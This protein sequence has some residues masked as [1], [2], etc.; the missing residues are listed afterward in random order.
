MECFIANP[1]LG[2]RFYPTLVKPRRES[3]LRTTEG[4]VGRWALSQPWPYTSCWVYR[5]L[6]W[7]ETLCRNLASITL[8]RL[9]EVQWDMLSPSPLLPKLAAQTFSEFISLLL[10]PNLVLSRSFSATLNGIPNF[11]LAGPHIELLSRQPIASEWVPTLLAQLPPFLSPSHIGQGTL[12]YR[13]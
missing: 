2:P 6:K 4:I 12:V 7:E 9:C 5:M 10:A 1:K 11:P 3:S 13:V 8:A